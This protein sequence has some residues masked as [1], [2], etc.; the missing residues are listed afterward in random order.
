MEGLGGLTAKAGGDD[1][2]DSI[3]EEEFGDDKRLDQHHG[4]CDDDG[5]KPDNVHHAE[6]VKDNVAWTSQLRAL[7]ERHRGG[8]SR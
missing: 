2:A 4:R 1:M 7:E 5:Q 8:V 3:E 6:N